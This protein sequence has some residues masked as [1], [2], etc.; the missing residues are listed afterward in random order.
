MLPPRPPRA[1]VPV[2]LLLVSLAACASNPE[3]ELIPDVPVR[4]APPVGAVKQGDCLEAR[5]R[6]AL[7]QDLEVDKL[8]TPRAMVPPPIPVKSM[9]AAVRHARYSEVRVTVLVDTLGRADMKTFTVVKST[10][11]WLASSVK[12]AVGKWTFESAELA[13]C[14][15]PRLYKWGATAGTPPA[16]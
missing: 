2:A 16:T 14:K 3:P 13:G 11:P 4:V 12:S 5:R 7:R 8:P 15:V 6:A 1:L 9:P 10:N